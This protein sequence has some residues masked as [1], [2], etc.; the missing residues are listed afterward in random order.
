MKF[1]DYDT[2][3]AKELERNRFMVIMPSVLLNADV[4]SAMEWEHGLGQSGI[5]NLLLMPH[6]SRTTPVK[7]Y[8]KQL[9]V[10]FHGGYLWLDKPYEVTVDLV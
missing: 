10:C 5:L 3:K 2:R 1:E 4:V 8:V 9:L 6:F 7:M